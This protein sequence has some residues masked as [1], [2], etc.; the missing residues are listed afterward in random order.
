MITYLNEYQH[1]KPK[2]LN[3]MPTCSFHLGIII[4]QCS[5]LN[6]MNLAK[7]RSN[8][9][10]GKDLLELGGRKGCERDT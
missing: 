3:V 8:E 9:L 2:S 1:K 5:G 10:E 7:N 4:G 6:D